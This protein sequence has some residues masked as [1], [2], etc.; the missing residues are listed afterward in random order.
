MTPYCE[1]HPVDIPSLLVALGIFFI[2]A[3][4]LTLTIYIDE[5]RYLRR[6]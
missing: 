6:R 5:R 1:A 4:T 3:G 2:V